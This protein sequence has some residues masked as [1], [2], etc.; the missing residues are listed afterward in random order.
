MADGGDGRAYSCEAY[1]NP[2]SNEAPGKP[3]RAALRQKWRGGALARRVAVGLPAIMVGAASTPCR[4][5]IARHNSSRANAA[6]SSHQTGVTS[7]P[8]GR[9]GLAA[10]IMLWERTLS[11]T[12]VVAG[13]KAD[14]VALLDG[15][16]SGASAHSNAIRIAAHRVAIKGILPRTIPEMADHPIMRSIIPFTKDV[17]TR[18]V[19]N[20]T[21]SIV[22][23]G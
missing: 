3:G 9:L 8:S 21:V 6:A 16:P 11:S 22:H 23:S 18:T 17:G 13:L 1:L 5:G 10:C 15:G 4:R 19:K 12:L 7:S 20:Q 14:P 2:F